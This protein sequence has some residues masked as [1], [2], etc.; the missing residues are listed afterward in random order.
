MGVV[1]LVLSGFSAAFTVALF[2]SVVAAFLAGFGVGSRRSWGEHLLSALILCLLF[3][4]ALS[5][6]GVGSADTMTRWIL[7]GLFVFMIDLGRREQGS[8]HASTVVWAL[9]LGSAAVLLRG[10]VYGPA[11][12]WVR[13]SW[14]VIPDRSQLFVYHLGGGVALGSFYLLGFA[15]ALRMP[16]R[17]ASWIGL[18]GAVFGV[19]VYATAWI[20]HL[21][22]FLLLHWPHQGWG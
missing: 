17:G 13:G 7:V 8:I 4:G 15:L 14:Q 1:D 9:L 11:L 16:R 3:A 22:Q 18:A 19:I 10:E 20:G 2:L 12:S 6:R 21:E 5:Q